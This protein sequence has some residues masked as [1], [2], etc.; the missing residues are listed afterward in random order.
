[1]V[2]KDITKIVMDANIKATGDRNSFL[3]TDSSHF[4][5]HSID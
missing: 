3:S 2:P 5:W 4:N 1:M